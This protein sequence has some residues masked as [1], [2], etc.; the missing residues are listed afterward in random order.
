MTRANS[1]RLYI[2]IMQ[3]KIIIWILILRKCV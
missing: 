1:L 2:K 3:L